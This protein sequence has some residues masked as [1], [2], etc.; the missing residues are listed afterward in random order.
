MNTNI[1]LSYY[2]LFSILPAHLT[3]WIFK[4]EIP[5]VDTTVQSEEWIP[6]N[7]YLMIMY[8]ISAWKR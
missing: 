1:E 5:N 4:S 2:T 8:K 6:N 7:E 3:I